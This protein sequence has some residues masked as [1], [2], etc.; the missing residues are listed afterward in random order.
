M[1]KLP[2]F[3]SAVQY[4]IPNL[5]LSTEEQLTSW[6]GI[7]ALP[8]QASSRCRTSMSLAMQAVSHHGS[9]PV[10]PEV[11][12]I[13]KEQTTITNWFA[14]A[15]LRPF[16]GLD[17]QSS[18]LPVTTHRILAPSQKLLATAGGLHATHGRRVS[19]NEANAD[20]VIITRFCSSASSLS[21]QNS[22]SASAN[23]NHA[24]TLTQAPSS[25]ALL[26]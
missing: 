20:P 25:S 10:A 23:S 6:P 18:A 9:R 21:M 22:A 11:C 2:I 1:E 3:D 5:H 14:P 8:M 15:S 19:T 4:W 26:P 16:P 13:S 7:A 24:P 17:P 12:V